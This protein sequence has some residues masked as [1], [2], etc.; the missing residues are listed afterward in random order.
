MLVKRPN[1]LPPQAGT[2]GSLTP[3]ASFAD[4]NPLIQI[5]YSDVVR[6]QTGYRISGREKSTLSLRTYAAHPL[7][8]GLS[9]PTTGFCHPSQGVTRSTSLG[10]QLFGS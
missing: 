9:W 6:R 7:L 5:G 3:F 4:T 1:Y 8:K 2:L 10:P